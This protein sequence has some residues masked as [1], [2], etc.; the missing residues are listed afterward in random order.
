MIKYSI[1][2]LGRVIKD[3]GSNSE[4]RPGTAGASRIIGVRYTEFRGL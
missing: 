4:L 1:Y 3:A 2:T